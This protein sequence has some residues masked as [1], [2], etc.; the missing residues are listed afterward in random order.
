MAPPKNRR[1]GF[2]R[3]AQ[4][5][6]FASY[7]IAVAG[8]LVGLLLLVT[9]WVD[10]AGHNAIRSLLSDITSPVSRVLTTVVRGTGSGGDSIAEYFRAGSKNA[11]LRAELD[12]A[13]RRLTAARATEYENKRLKR[14][15]AIREGDPAAIVTARLVSSSATSTRRFAIL[16][17]GAS[18]GVANGQP[19][20]GPDGLV[21]RV[22]ET[23]RI[24]ARV[25]LIT[26]TGNVV[27]V[28]RISDGLPAIVTGNGEG[29]VEI[30]ALTSGANVLRIGDVFVTSGTGGVYPPQ[31]PVAIAT[32]TSG[33][34]AVGRVLA[35]PSRL[36]YAIV[37]PIFQPLAAAPPAA[38]EGAPE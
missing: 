21:G 14:L 4:Y 34:A 17:A 5:G 20:R 22:V 29:T 18:S 31:I 25:L 9:A 6:L 19:V 16:D 2:S 38:V 10:P 28:I 1:P 8:A 11:E 35:D 12:T 33:D 37:Q 13:R 32:T 24:T 23:G 36:D 15:L 7:V 27:P 3:K 26:D 30:R